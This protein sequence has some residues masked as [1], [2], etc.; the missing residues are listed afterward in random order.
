MAN[1]TTFTVTEAGAY[2]ARSGRVNVNIRLSLFL[3]QHPLDADQ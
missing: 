3:Y 1:P 2:T